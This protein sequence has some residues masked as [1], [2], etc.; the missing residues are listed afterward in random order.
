MYGVWGWRG[1]NRN[2]VQTAQRVYAKPEAHEMEARPGRRGGGGR[3]VVGADVH[4]RKYASALMAR[5]DKLVVDV[6]GYREGGLQSQTHG[7]PDHTHTHITHTTGREWSR[8]GCAWELVS[9]QVHTQSRKTLVVIRTSR[10]KRGS[11]KVSLS[12]RQRKVQ[13]VAIIV[14]PAPSSAHF[15][16][17]GVATIV[18]SHNHTQTKILSNRHMQRNPV[19]AN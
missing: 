12:G 8:R 15:L 2:I 4:D 18:R 14:H 17:V 7:E 1:R 19:Q 16:W 9:N 3:G 11:Q 6:S 5:P 13:R 10:V